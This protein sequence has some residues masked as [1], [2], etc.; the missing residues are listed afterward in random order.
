[1]SFSKSSA[2]SAALQSGPQIYSMLNNIGNNPDDIQQR[3]IQ[4][5]GSRISV[6]QE[7]IQ[8]FQRKLAESNDRLR[9]LKQAQLQKQRATLGIAALQP[10]SQEVEDEVLLFTFMFM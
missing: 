1:M 3:R 7:Q 5:L 6:L 8:S 4:V 9:S 2:T 10:Q